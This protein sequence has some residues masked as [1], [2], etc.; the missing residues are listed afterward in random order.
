MLLMV[1]LNNNGKL[2]NSFSSRPKT[3]SS[4]LAW[5]KEFSQTSKKAVVIR[6]HSIYLYYAGVGERWHSEVQHAS[7]LVM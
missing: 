1:I 6:Y 5:T 3:T 2:E 4:I 7:L